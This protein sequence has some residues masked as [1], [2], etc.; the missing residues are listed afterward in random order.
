MAQTSPNFGGVL[1]ETCH[2]LPLR[3][4]YED[5]D[6]SGIVYHANYLRFFE[7]GRTEFIRALGVDQLA[8]HRDEGVAFA[9]RSI[10]VEFLRPALMDDIIEV[11]TKAGEVR[12]PSLHLEQTI[13]RGEEVLTTAKVLVVCIRNGRPQRLPES[14]RKVLSRT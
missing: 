8:L 2:R 10:Q 5:T 11:G 4:Y 14:L 9:V 3:V 7:R 12:G 13:R 6:F 1:N